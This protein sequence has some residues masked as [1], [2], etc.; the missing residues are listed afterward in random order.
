MAATCESRYM[1]Q[2]VGA[3]KR[4]VAPTILPVTQDEVE[5]EL[6]ILT[7]DEAMESKYDRW[8]REAVDQVERDAG[9]AITTQTWQLSLDHF[10]RDNI[11]IKR[12][13]IQSVA[14]LKYYA[15]D[16]LTTWGSGNYVT[17]LVAAPA[18]ISPASGLYW[19]AADSR[20]NSIQ[21]QFVAGFAS[22]DLVPDFIKQ[23]IL[24]VVKAKQN[25]C[26][27]GEYYWTMINRLREWGSI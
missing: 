27:M 11:E 2:M 16:V 1:H 12:W 25:G 4:T 10:P 15:D 8:I 22:A 21:V 7:H 3:Y 17:D 18:R 26:D 5:E 24:A 19:P 13:P 6:D 20:L 9:I 23:T 14:H